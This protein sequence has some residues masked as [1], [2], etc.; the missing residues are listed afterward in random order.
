[1]VQNDQ[2]SSIRLKV[3]FFGYL[4]ELV[5]KKE[6][7]IRFSSATISLGEIISVILEK[8]PSLSHS[9]VPYIVSVN[10]KIADKS[11]KINANDEVAFLP[12]VSGG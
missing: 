4:H 12:P 11:I 10:Q 6:I 2:F 8:Y 9:T 7:K 1:M 3:K 5:G